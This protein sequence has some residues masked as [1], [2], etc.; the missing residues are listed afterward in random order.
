MRWPK[1]RAVTRAFR[2]VAA[3]PLNTGTYRPMNEQASL[4]S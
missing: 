3:A 1:A 4:S 2:E